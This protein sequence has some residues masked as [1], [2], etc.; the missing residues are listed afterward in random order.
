MK[1][2]SAFFFFFKEILQYVTTWTNPEDIMLN[3]ISQS[4]MTN[5]AGFHLYNF[6]KIVRL[7]IRVAWWLPGDLVREKRGVTGQQVYV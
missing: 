2:Y 3:E 5:T 6:A 7:R 4:E 1:Y